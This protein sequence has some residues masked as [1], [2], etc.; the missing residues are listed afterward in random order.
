MSPL[1]AT[2]ILPVL[3]VLCKGGKNIT[4]LTSERQ[5]RE[6]LLSSELD[7]ELSSSQSRIRV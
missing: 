5:L 2:M 4:T 7:S 1:I 6:P 3:S